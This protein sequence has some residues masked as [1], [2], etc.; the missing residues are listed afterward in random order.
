M[1]ISRDYATVAFALAGTLVLVTSSTG[2]QA[3]QPLKI[4]EQGSFFVGGEQVFSETGNDTRVISSRNP[5]TTTINQMYV[6]YQIPQ[7]QKF[8]YP[9]ILMHGGGHEGKVYEMTPDGREGWDTYFLRKGFAVYNVDATNR[10]ASGFDMRQIALVAQ[11]DENAEIPSMNKYT[12][13][14]ACTQFR[15]G[16]FPDDECVQHE[17]GQFP[18]EAFESQYLSQLVPAF[19]D[20]TVT[21]GNVAALVALVDRIGPAIFLTWSQSG[22]FGY[23]ACVQRPQ[24]CKGNISLEPSGISRPGGVSNT[25]TQDDLAVLNGIPILIEVGDFDPD[26]ETGMD[27]F[28]GFINDAGPGENASV[29]NL[30]RDHGI[31]GN[32]H[33]VMLEKNNIAVADLIIEWIKDNDLD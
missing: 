3:A 19:R 21:P 5:G 17:G 29:L 16:T 8:K 2:T 9:I 13:E 23:L 15:I 11:G 28:A 14:L 33:V 18:L 20:D 7:N 25:L 27:N 10:G 1:K 30:P 24:L 26:R 31:N 4:A 22:H 32:G 12:K 6:Q